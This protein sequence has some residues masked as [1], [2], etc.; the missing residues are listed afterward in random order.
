MLIAKTQVG[1]KETEGEKDQGVIEGLVLGGMAVQDLV[2]MHYGR[3]HVEK[4]PDW[5]EKSGG[6]PEHTTDCRTEQHTQRDRGRHQADG[7][8]QLP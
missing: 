6:A 8:L 7:A 1:H 3:Q 2:E 4:S 5:D